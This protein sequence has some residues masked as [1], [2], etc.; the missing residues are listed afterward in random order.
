MGCVLVFTFNPYSNNYPW[1]TMIQRMDTLTLMNDKGDIVMQTQSKLEVKNEFDL[2]L[3][4]VRAVVPNNWNVYWSWEAKQ[5]LKKDRHTCNIQLQVDPHRDIL[6]DACCGMVH[7]LRWSDGIM[8]TQIYLD[9]DDY[10]TEQRLLH[11]LAH[12]AEQN[13]IMV[14]EGAFRHEGASICGTIYSHMN[15]KD[16]RDPPDPAVITSYKYG[17]HG[18]L[19][20]RCLRAFH[21]RAKRKGATLDFSQLWR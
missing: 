10:D 6:K 8:F 20:E 19:F 21:A 17:D 7:Y 2:I 13:Y 11:E 1:S 16:D 9:T 5:R 4:F 12:V 3:E 15:A 18:E 14:K